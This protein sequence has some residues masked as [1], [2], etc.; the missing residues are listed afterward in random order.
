MNLLS[1]TATELGTAIR[2]GRTTA[3]DAVRAVFECV[4]QYEKEYRCFITMDQEAALSRAAFVQEEIEA[5][6]LR[7]P[8][9]GVPVAIKDNLC[10]AGMKTTC[11]SKMLEHFVPFYS[12]TAVNR[13]KDA[14]AVIIG[15]TNMDEFAMGSTTENSAFGITRNP[16]DP[17]YSPGGSSGGSAAAVVLGECSYA[18]GTDTGGSVRQPASHCGIVGMKPTYG[19]VSRY[20]LVAYGSSLDQIGPLCKSVEDCAVILDTISGPDPKDATS[21]SGGY[22]N[23]IASLTDNVA[24]M[25]IGIPVDY[26]G[27]D[28]DPEIVETLFQVAGVYREAGAFVEEFELGMWEYVIPAYY[29]IACAEASSNLE[30]FDGIKY[31][32]RA[33]GAE[34]IRQLYKMSRTEGFGTE[35]KRRIMLGSFVLSSGFY[36]DYYLKALK[37]RGMLKENMN[38]AFEKY[39]CIL[40]PV[41]PSTAPKLGKFGEDPIK[42]YLEDIYTVP[43]NLLGLPA[44]SVPGGCDSLGHPIGIQLMGNCFEERK[45]IRATYT[46]EQSSLAVSRTKRSRK[47][48]LD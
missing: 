6:R 40:M 25:R 24:G 29:T 41:T 45:L 32:Y 26:L 38:N 19:T 5:G 18:L 44:I 9:A 10:T 1:L 23:L 31:G 47:G 30:R 37:V 36:D 16:R 39:D 4:T 42:M 3:V 2:E 8:L 43:A 27:R 15:K 13:L 11:G 17:D 14:G 34:D 7:H 46:F 21:V 28:S 22:E 35:V 20:G 48:G 12:A 33:K